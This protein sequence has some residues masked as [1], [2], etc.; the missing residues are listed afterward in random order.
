MKTPKQFLIVVGSLFL[1]FGGLAVGRFALAPAIQKMMDPPKPKTGTI[2]LATPDGDDEEDHR[3]GI[4]SGLVNGS[5]GDTS[6]QTDVW[7]AILQSENSQN[8]HD[9][10]SDD[11]DVTQQPDATGVWTELWTVKACGDMRSYK[12]KFTPN[13]SGGTSFEISG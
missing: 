12:V 1:L 9:I 5:L 2:I 7:K 8:C 10:I 4:V 11:I 6:L 13:P 3:P